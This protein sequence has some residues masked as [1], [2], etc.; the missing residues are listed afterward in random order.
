MTPSG[1][2]EAESSVSRRGRGGGHFKRRRL[3]DLA[4]AGGHGSGA[5]AG[6]AGGYTGAPRGRPRKP[7]REWSEFTTGDSDEDLE[8]SEDDGKPPLRQFRVCRGCDLPF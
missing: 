2:D 5:G 1:A 6:A 4:T 3:V 8:I 7:K